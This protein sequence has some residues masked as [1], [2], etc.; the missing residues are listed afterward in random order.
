MRSD[1]AEYYSIYPDARPSEESF[2]TLTAAADALHLNDPAAPSEDHDWTETVYLG[3]AIPEKY[4]NGQIYSWLHPRSRSATGGVFVYQ[5]INPYCLQADHYD[6]RMHLPFPNGDLDDVD[7]GNGLR[8]QT[9]KP[10]E[11]IDV[12]YASEDGAVEFD[13][14]YTAVMPA[15]GRLDHK[16]LAQ[17]MRVRGTLKLHGETH[18]VDSHFTRDRSWNQVRPETPQD[19]P[20]IT[21][22]A[23]TFADDLSFHFVGFDDHDLQPE[24][25]DAYPR[26]SMPDP[27]R[28]GWAWI[29]GEVRALSRMRKL[30]R[31]GDDG[32]SPVAATIELTDDR[33]DVHLLEGRTTALVAQP[34][35]QNLLVQWALMEYTYDG[36]VG[37]GDYQD[38]QYHSFVRRFARRPREAGRL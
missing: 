26:E 6:W 8:M 17:T 27:L 13:L 31:R 12:Q 5:G 4:I 34:T 15:V 2:A 37:Y 24:W 20:P 9:R 21:W 30:T 22:G 23:A 36:Q 10:L 33:G 35:F 16:H 3:F 38:C 32:T 11:M 18:E 25:A 29:G 7:F 14:T 19:I 1:E 28:W